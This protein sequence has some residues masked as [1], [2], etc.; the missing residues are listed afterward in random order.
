[1]YIKYKD[2]IGELIH[3]E[4]IEDEY[5]IMDLRLA[6]NIIIKITCRDWQITIP[7]VMGNSRILYELDK[8]KEGGKNVWL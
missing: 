3:Y 7:N 2:Y 5:I 4:K 8:A 1:M 6:D